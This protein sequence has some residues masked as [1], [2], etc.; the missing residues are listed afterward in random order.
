MEAELEEQ[1]IAPLEKENRQLLKKLGTMER[2][3]GRLAKLRRAEERLLVLQGDLE[4]RERS[5][6]AEVLQ[7]ESEVRALAAERDILE[8]QVDGLI[9][10]FTL[11]R[12]GDLELMRKEVLKQ[13]KL[14]QKKLENREEEIA[15]LRREKRRLELEVKEAHRHTYQR[16]S[17]QALQHER[18]EDER[19]IQQLELRCEGLM[20]EL[21]SQQA[22]MEHNRAAVLGC[23]DRV[24]ML[25]GDHF[26]PF[27]NEHQHLMSLVTAL[28]DQL[29]DSVPRRST[30][31]R[32]DSNRPVGG[33]S[34]ALD[35]ETK[36]KRFSL[37]AEVRVSPNH[38]G[39]VIEAVDV[40]GAADRA[41]LL[42]GDVITRWGDVR[43]TSE[44]ALVKQ[45]EEA[46]HE[47]VLTVVRGGHTMTI[48]LQL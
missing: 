17:L 2:M 11:P 12:Q 16:P 46:T 18:I 24:R 4:Q 34:R 42:P 9:Q 40:N 1:V 38:T 13:R 10:E 29:Q 6:E 33:W 7:M 35:I 22:H 41:G 44:H 30:H 21:D 28:C 3:E 32:G 8:G 36:P 23:I 20:A 48:P 43:I 26:G 45:L 25:V 39:V 47:A 19:V 5:T 27:Q 15:E 31:L 14:F 37:G